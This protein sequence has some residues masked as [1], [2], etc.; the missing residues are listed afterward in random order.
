MMENVTH[1]R[2]MRN[3]YETLI[4]KP[5]ERSSRRWEGSII[6]DIADWMK[7]NSDMVQWQILLNT[8]MNLL[9]PWKAASFSTVWLTKSL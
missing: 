4:V 9:V 3:A 5:F 7:L 1:M 6:W 2:D 8:V